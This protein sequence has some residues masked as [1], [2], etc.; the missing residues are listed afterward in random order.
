M[1]RLLALEL[2]VA[3]QALDLRALPQLAPRIA[4]IMAEIR[5]VVPHLDDDRPI[6]RDVEA[7]SRKLREVALADP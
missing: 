5:A 3:A 2:I 1:S 6:G 4:R 7:L